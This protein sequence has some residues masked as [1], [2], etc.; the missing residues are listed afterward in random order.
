MILMTESQAG[1]YTVGV[2]MEEILSSVSTLLVYTLG[3]RAIFILSIS[4]LLA[5]TVKE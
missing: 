5:V 2:C 3:A 4:F 1:A